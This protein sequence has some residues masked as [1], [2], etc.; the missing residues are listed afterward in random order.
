MRIYYGKI[1]WSPYAVN[2]LFVLVFPADLL[3][4]DPVC[5]YW[6]WTKDSKGNPKVNCT[7]SSVITG[8]NTGDSNGVM[9]LAFIFDNY[10]SFDATVSNDA[11]TLQ[12][13]MSNPA[14]EKSGVMTLR[15]SYFDRNKISV[16][17]IFTGK[18]SWSYYLSDEMIIAV[19]PN[20]SVVKDGDQ[21]CLYFQ[22]TKDASGVYKSNNSVV[23]KLYSV[24]NLSDGQSTMQFL[25]NDQYYTWG[26]T[27]SADGDTLTLE[28]Q[29][30]SKNGGRSTLE[31]VGPMTKASRKAL[32]VRY[33]TG[34]DSGIF[35]VQKLLTNTLGFDR[36][37]IT[38]L[39]YNTEPKNSDRT[40][41]S[42]QKPPTATRF[43]EEFKNLL[44]NAVRG[45]V[46]FLYVDAHGSPRDA[47]DSSGEK[48]GVDEGWKLAKDDNGR[49]AEVVYDNWLTTVIKSMLGPGVNLTILTSSCL[50]GGMLDTHNGTPGVLLAGCHET[51]ANVKAFK[52]KDPWTAAII[53]VVA[54]HQKKKRNL[55]TYAQLYISA[56]KYI[57][58]L[59][60]NGYISGKLY[61]GPSKDEK[62]PDPH[63]PDRSSHQD[64]QL[65]FCQDYIN[66][67]VDRFLAPFAQWETQT[68]SMNPGPAMRFPKEEL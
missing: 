61:L 1:H 40:C 67:D 46:R 21:I 10:Y 35:D 56:K 38:M 20:G 58:N 25:S 32:I 11:S 4:K 62:H 45:D 28:M 12:V 49:Q 34:T 17:K 51:Q 43:K 9:R 36:K 15:Q 59:M 3:L 26:G 24:A 37:S 30:P 55:P 5:G 7:Q 18:F 60:Q 63:R 41:T 33:D 64:P 52:G 27:L 65:V 39:Y 23:N 31:R 42:G 68:A 44:R 8:V 29:D 48:D 66:V 13:T 16:S 57:I 54:G 14:G 19:L 6:Q 53:H 50:G 2:E 22:W 47:G